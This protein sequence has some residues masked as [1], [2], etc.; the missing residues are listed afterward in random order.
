MTFIYYIYGIFLSLSPLFIFSV[1]HWTNVHWM[2]DHWTTVTV[3]WATSYTCSNHML[4]RIWSQ[5]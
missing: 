3:H 2:A 4:S 1:D 5:M